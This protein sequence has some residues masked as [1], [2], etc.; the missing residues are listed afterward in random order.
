MTLVEVGACVGMERVGAL[1]LAIGLLKVQRTTCVS[2]D[3]RDRAGLRAWLRQSRVTQVLP[4][5]PL[6]GALL[7]LGTLVGVFESG[8]E[9]K[10]SKRH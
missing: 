1:V 5:G 3:E 4:E 10:G 9:S 7:L 6:V 8:E 2:S